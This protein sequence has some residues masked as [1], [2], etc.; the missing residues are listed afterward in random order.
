MAANGTTRDSEPMKFP[1]GAS[2]PLRTGSGYDFDFRASATNVN[3]RIYRVSMDLIAD[4]P[5]TLP[6]SARC[7]C[8]AIE[9]A[10]LR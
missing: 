9:A 4:G 3:F 7:P 2:Y 6:E 5:Y 10:I 8:F 1:I